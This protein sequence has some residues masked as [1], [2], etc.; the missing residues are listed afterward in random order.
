MVYV[1]PI[2]A[3]A[4]EVATVEVY[5]VP[6]VMFPLDCMLFNKS[7]WKIRGKLAYGTLQTVV[8]AKAVTE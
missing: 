4:V 1:L 6:D 3:A 5:V 7:T 8:V 2:H